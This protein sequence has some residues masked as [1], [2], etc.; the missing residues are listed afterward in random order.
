MHAIEEYV[1][2]PYLFGAPRTYTLTDAAGSTFEKTYTPHNFAGFVQRYDRV[3]ALL[4]DRRLV[5]GHI[6][7]ASAYLIDTQAL[8]QRALAQLKR[9][10]YFFVD[11]DTN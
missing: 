10:P 5:S 6:G 4:D 2:P 8:Y 7:R 11:R 9:D 3:A 1:Q